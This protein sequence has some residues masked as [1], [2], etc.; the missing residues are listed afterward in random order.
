MTT[1]EP[2]DAAEV[3]E[4]REAL[5][6]MKVRMAHAEEHLKTCVTKAEFLVVKWVVFLLV[7]SS[8]T[9]VLSAVLTKAIGR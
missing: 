2:V 7:G 1:R 3:T 9:F 4:M 5:A 8:L 6:E